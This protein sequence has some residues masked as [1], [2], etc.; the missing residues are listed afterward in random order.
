MHEPEPI[1]T[2]SASLLEAAI[3]KLTPKGRE[4]YHQGLMIADSSVS[5]KELNVPVPMPANGEVIQRALDY[6]H[7][8]HR[9]F[10]KNPPI[11]YL[12][13]PLQVLQ[14]I[15]NWGI[16]NTVYPDLW[17]AALLHDTVEDTEATIGE[18]EELF[19]KN[20]AEIVNALTFNPENGLTKEEYLSTLAGHDRIVILVIKIADRICNVYD[21]VSH[22]PSYAVKYFDKAKV[23]F[24]AVQ[25]RQ[26]EIADAYGNQVCN[27]IL[28]SC[29]KQSDTI[30]EYR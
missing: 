1:M 20:V 15:A 4:Y 3:K 9:S 24:D 27:R 8:H 7:K 19:G 10:R 18:I 29:K 13:H 11:P 23:L 25:S 12:I 5:T 14:R 6:A 22:Q 17:V 28:S 16:T 21:F 2:D 26:V 30:N